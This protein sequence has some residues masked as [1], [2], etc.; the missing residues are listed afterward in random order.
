MTD[1]EPP[2][3]H[4]AVAIPDRVFASGIHGETEFNIEPGPV[5]P[6]EV[7]WT[8]SPVGTTTPEFAVVNWDEVEAVPDPSKCPDCL[9]ET[10]EHRP[11]FADYCMKCGSYCRCV[12][13][14]D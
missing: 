14:R 9:C 5:Q 4:P 8:D 7:R 13:S 6:M 12:G 2:K 3:N 10:E 1:N 11:A